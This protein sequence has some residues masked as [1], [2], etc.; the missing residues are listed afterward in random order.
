MKIFFDTNVVIEHLMQRERFD[1]M[2]Q[3][4][5]RFI[6]GNHVL[7]MSVGGFYTILYVVDRFLS[8]EMHLEKETRIAVVRNMAQG[9]LNNYIIAGYDN[10]S[11]LRS[12]NDLRFDDLEDNCQLQ[13]AVSAG[14]QCLLTFNAKDYPTDDN[15]IKVMTPEQFLVENPLKS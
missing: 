9:L 8:K 1:F 12:I 5:T 11:L 10:E 7:Y 4:F 3:V 13:A 2:K 14:C 15:Q 6:D